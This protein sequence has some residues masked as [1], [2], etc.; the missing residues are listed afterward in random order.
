M[1]LWS[2]LSTAT[3]RPF[4][5]ATDT[6]RKNI[7]ALNTF[8]PRREEH[9]KSRVAST[10]ASKQVATEVPGWPV[11]VRRVASA[12]RGAKKSLTREKRRPGSSPRRHTSHKMALVGMSP[13][14]TVRF[15]TL[16]ARAS[17]VHG[18]RCVVRVATRGVPRRA[19]SLSTRAV[20]TAGSSGGDA[21]SVGTVIKRR[22]PGAGPANGSGYVYKPATGMGRGPSPGGM[23]PQNFRVLAVLAAVAAMNATFSALGGPAAASASPAASALA[24]AALTYAA[25]WAHALWR[26]LENVAIDQRTA[27]ET[28]ATL[29]SALTYG[30]G[31]LAVMCVVECAKTSKACAAAALAASASVCVAR[32]L[33]KELSE[34]LTITV[35]KESPGSETMV[36]TAND[37]MLAPTREGM[38]SSATAGLAGEKSRLEVLERL[39]ELM[40]KEF[41]E[42][43]ARLAQIES[44]KASEVRRLEGIYEQRIKTLKAEIVILRNKNEQLSKY[45]GIAA[46]LQNVEERMTQEI[47]RMKDA[48]DSD[49]T[50]LKTQI[51]S[52]EKT[53]AETE[54]KANEER[55]RLTAALRAA[56]G[57]YS[58][59]RRIF[60]SEMAKY[61]AA[62][63]LADQH[64]EWWKSESARIEEHLQKRIAA[65]EA[66]HAKALANASASERSSGQAALNRA[67]ESLKV[68]HTLE[69]ESTMAAATAE[70]KA[71]QVLLEDE[72]A[73]AAKQ[74]EMSVKSAVA[75]AEVK[76][77]NEWRERVELLE[78]QHAATIKAVAA[79]YEDSVKEE[80]AFNDQ[81]VENLRGAYESKIEM[82]NANHAEA[83]Q[84]A[85]DVAAESLM[86]AKKAAVAELAKNNEASAQELEAT[87][88]KLEAEEEALIAKLTAERDEVVA[89]VRA[90]LRTA[91]AERGALYE[92]FTGEKAK[93][94]S[95]VRARLTA[96]IAEA[97]KNFNAHWEGETAKLQAA[98]DEKIAE[99]KAAQDEALATMQTAQD[100]EIEML[101]SQ[102]EKDR[103]AAV[104][105]VRAALQQAFDAKSRAAAGER[106]ALKALMDSE[107]AKARVRMLAAVDDAVADGVARLNAAKLVFADE[108]EQLQRNFGKEMDNVKAD[109][110]ARLEA[111]L[112]DKASAVEKLWREKLNEAEKQS[113]TAIALVK[114]TAAKKAEALENELQN[115]KDVA[116][117][118]L[119]AAK[120]AAEKDRATS[121]SALNARIDE[122]RREHDEAIASAEAGYAQALA[123]A[124][125][126]ATAEMKSRDEAADA[127]YAELE[128][129]AN[130]YQAAVAKAESDLAAASE[131]AAE[132]LVQAEARYKEELR[133]M[134]DEKDGA[135]AASVASA[136][137]EA[138]EISDRLMAE[139]NET[140]AAY[141]QEKNAL[142]VEHRKE[143]KE[144][145]EN[146]AKE[147]ADAAAT[148][149]ALDQKRKDALNASGSEFADKLLQ[150][151]T[152]LAKT[153]KEA[154]NALTR[155]AAA[156]DEAVAEVNASMAAKLQQREEEL[157]LEIKSL[158]EYHAEELGSIKAAAAIEVVEAQKKSQEEVA[159]LN[160]TIERM[161][162][163]HDKR[164]AEAAE[165]AKSAIKDLEQR[166]LAA[167]K[168]ADDKVA[169]AKAESTAAL[170]L[171]ADDAAKQLAE[172]RATLQAEMDAIKADAKAKAERAKLAYQD[173]LESAKKA[174]AEELKKAVESNPSVDTEAFE[175]E[176]AALDEKLKAQVQASDEAYERGKAEAEKALAEARFE[177]EGKLLAAEAAA[178]TTLEEERARFE[179]AM[180]KQRSEADAA[181][182]A[183]EDAAKATIEETRAKAAEELKSVMA[184][185]DTFRDNL[186]RQFKN[187]AKRARDEFDA[188]IKAYDQKLLDT[189][190]DLTARHEQE[191]KDLLAAHASEM[192]A[193][194]AALDAESRTAEEVRAEMARMRQTHEAEFKAALARHAD[195]L[196][197]TARKAKAALLEVT[198]R[199]V[200]QV[201]A[202][203]NDAAADRAAAVEKLEKR[204]DSLV[205]ER[206]DAVA[207]ARRAVTDDA[208]WLANELECI[209]KAY[210]LAEDVD[211]STV[212]PEDETQR[213]RLEAAGEVAA[214]GL[215]GIEVPVW[216]YY[217]L[218]LATALLP[219]IIAGGGM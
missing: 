190:R 56:R 9:S 173:A 87:V 154:E 115:A 135:L 46:A 130:E 106:R 20:S 132:K 67:I 22:S 81:H 212:D 164:M 83:L 201:E 168:D 10:E 143:L 6:K 44:E 74:L 197:D 13:S 162:A 211:L 108:K 95:I 166:V 181:A 79:D 96:E 76:V 163:D 176:Y 37:V 5:F 189:S 41:Q 45:A 126:A 218:G 137:R 34:G 57:L 146:A 206:D 202:A 204:I 80:R 195:E 210:A 49:I 172:Q 183:A 61:R 112:A 169:A 51:G 38:Q 19:V 77:A 100:E 186:D 187:E 199:A 52:L 84:N 21:A 170:K 103:N 209:K 122:M 124:A 188:Q 69:M 182:R 75:E 42:E 138:D 208:H 174:A 91:R 215:N 92:H 14:M 136:A 107:R 7:S 116:A 114:E 175:L 15:A 134:S 144:V 94:E 32:Y 120:A 101:E 60:D 139:L 156:Q 171:A 113:A 40:M 102:I 30:F 17:G 88:A 27:P 50:A 73:D 23:Q 24:S 193:K 71:L 93:L 12:A 203:R 155:A 159:S 141:A 151:E 205:G 31:S 214:K 157:L 1:G 78:A 131:A 167:S 64:T 89:T 153:K 36:V 90:E 2:A 150:M 26:K 140:K 118:T 119:M 68:Q 33:A 213:K 35:T 16:S 70:R 109:F 219:R 160:R 66:A 184:S 217:A 158:R 54:A 99:L 200:E 39:K 152:A 192:E 104:E 105:S 128:A 110:A 196:E 86:A 177:Y 179:A 28:K 216:G 59:Q 53:I 198:E 127:K 3:L 85:K 191:T 129:K 194:Q 165:A 145:M 4:E 147:M 25:F 123:A 65:T 8:G 111:E 48:Y 121:V 149:E 178:A 97:E 125:T 29:A 11:A 133:R 117:E 55:E 207:R 161:Q 185:A 98:H 82:L 43:T 47:A 142:M 72:R 180:A 18:G 148:M 62:L 63:A 58:A